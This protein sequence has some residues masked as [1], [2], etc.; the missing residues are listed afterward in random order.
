MHIRLMLPSGIFKDQLKHSAKQFL[1]GANKP[2]F[3]LSILPGL[4]DFV[5]SLF[6]IHLVHNSVFDTTRSLSAQ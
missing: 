4:D 6:T 1:G 2:R 3:L 5:E